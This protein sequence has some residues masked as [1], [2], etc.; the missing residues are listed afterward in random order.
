M[1][2]SGHGAE[3]DG[4]LL[5]DV[6]DRDQNELQQKQ[7]VAPLRA[8]LRR[9][10]DAAGV[11]VGQH[12]DNAGAGDGEEAAPAK[13]GR[14]ESADSHGRETWRQEREHIPDW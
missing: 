10:D 7:A 4:Q 5:H 2:L 3:A 9:R 13:G 1:S 12:H 8:A 14:S 11:G 6:E